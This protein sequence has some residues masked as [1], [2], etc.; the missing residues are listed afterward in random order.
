[1]FG[2]DRDSMRR[3]FL[4]AWHKARDGEPLPLRQY[5]EQEVAKVHEIVR[6]AEEEETTNECRKSSDNCSHR[7]DRP[8]RLYRAP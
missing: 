8:G 7:G 4:E 1:M 5:R 3:F 6:G 2:Q